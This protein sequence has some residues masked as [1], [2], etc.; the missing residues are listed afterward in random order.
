MKLV[1]LTFPFKLD[2]YANCIYVTVL[3]L[4]ENLVR[5]TRGVEI[6]S[7]SYSILARAL[8]N[9]PE[10]Q[11]HWKPSRKH[12]SA[13]TL[14]EGLLH[15][16]ESPG[17]VLFWDY[18]TEIAT[19]IALR[20]WRVAVEEFIEDACASRLLSY[21]EI[22]KICDLLESNIW[23]LDGV[24]ATRDSSHGARM[25]GFIGLMKRMKRY[26]ELFVWGQLL[27]EGFRTKE[28]KDDEDNDTDST[29]SS[30]SGVH[31]RG[32]EVVDKET[33]QSI[34][35]V[36][37]L[38]GVLLPFSIIAAIFSM[39]G[40]YQPGGNQFFIFW[41]IAIPI[42]MLTTTLIYADSIRRMTLEQF[43]HEY[44][45][46]AVKEDVDDMVASSISD[47]EIISYKA[48][49]KERLASR[50]PGPWNRRRS[51]AT[52][53][54]SGNRTD[55][56]SDDYTSSTNSNQ[57][58]PELSIDGDL[59]VRKKK[60]KEPR[61]WSWRFW[62]RKP[63]D[64]T[65]DLE[66]VPP[67]P[68]YSTPKIPSPPTATPPAAAPPSPPLPPQAATPGEAMPS[69]S[70]PP[71]SFRSDHSPI[72]G[73]APPQTPST[74][75]SSPIPAP[76][77]PAPD[78]PDLNLDDDFSDPHDSHPT[79][80]SI[81]PTV[82]DPAEIPLPPSPDSTSDDWRERDSSE[83]IRRE[84]SPL[85]ELVD[86]DYATDRERRSLERRM[87]DNDELELRERR[88][89]GRVGSGGNYEERI[90]ERE[91][92]YDRRRRSEHFDSSEEERKLILER[93]IRKFVE[94]QETGGTL[95]DDDDTISED[96][97]RR[98]RRPVVQRSRRG[99]YYSYPR[100]ADSDVDPTEVPLPPSPE[101]LTEEGRAI[102][103]LEKERFEY[104]K[105][106]K[107]EENW[108]RNE[109][110]GGS[111]RKKKRAVDEE[112]KK[113]EEEEHARWQEYMK[114]RT[115]EN[116]ARKRAEEEYIKKKLEEEKEAAARRA[117]KGKER[118]YSPIVS[119]SKKEKPA[120]KFKD[121][122]GRKFTF[123]FHLVST[124]AVSQLFLSI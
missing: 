108:K 22:H 4:L 71:E 73:P 97:G 23:S 5:A 54:S 123:P 89:R 11:Q 92:I 98:R 67:S 102:K 61:S 122:V 40:N 74:S 99:T 36:T 3:L 124:W 76:D 93:T 29:A 1:R 59:L 18:L 116:H 62:R 121:A 113:W 49:I 16:V 2:R 77:I 48:G 57:L 118:A 60:K 69:G 46:A 52:S 106:L 47:S 87:R 19:D 55:S 12:D 50:M 110:A 70:P 111:A 56:D 94:E 41:V 25:F 72:A 103:K 80:P 96:R 28:S 8:E 86:S 34:N 119:D 88:R 91:I 107:E 30:K 42:C 26:T 10:E 104:L 81:H 63:L 115:E 84:R 35:R 120:I 82:P 78:I 24:E 17:G 100:R 21:H 32:G 31:I 66:N 6:S 112:L 101:E 65:S 95:R 79:S 43:A 109:E 53:S 105:K 37:Y 68:T 20:K 117:A 38:G 85:A 33:R 45:P 64:K 58:P 83:I 15:A 27:E 75:P 7:E 51:Y 13:L 90:I 114:K 44:G 39:G 9:L 14:A